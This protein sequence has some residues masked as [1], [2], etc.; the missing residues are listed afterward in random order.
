MAA[1]T[2]PGGDN[3]GVVLRRRP[4]GLLRHEDVEL[5]PL[6]V[7]EPPPGGIVVRTDRI[8]IDATVRSWLQAGQGYFPAVEIGEVV[9]SSGI[10]RVVV[11]DSPN[12]REGDVVTALTGWQR[13]V[14]LPDDILATNVGPADEVDQEA[15]LAVYG[16]AGMTAYLGMLEVGEVGPGDRVLVSAAA[17]ATGSIAAQLAKLQGATVVGVAGTD[18]KCRWLVD[19]LGLAGAVNHRTADL[20]AEL[21]AHFPKGIDVFFDNVG[22]TVLDLALARIANGG[23]VVLC[24]AISSYNDDHRPPGPANYLNLIQREA[25]MRGFLTL[26]HWDRFGEIQPVLEGLVEAGDLRYRTEVFQGLESAVDALN[27]MFTGA[28]TGK[29]VIEL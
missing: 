1:A 16:S 12:Y 20:A 27:A 10:G 3:E 21:K 25:S 29:I 15:H 17:G 5:V 14:A 6:P 9:R 2:G 7:P 26:N 8:G 11:T 24:G 4:V 23:R 18:E 19:D 28:N 13:Y 22:G